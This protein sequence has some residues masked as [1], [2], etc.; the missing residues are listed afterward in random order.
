M[1]ET[2]KALLLTLSYPGVVSPHAS[3]LNAIGTYLLYDC[4]NFHADLSPPHDMTP[5]T[6]CLLLHI[7]PMPIIVCD[8]D[9]P[10]QRI[11]KPSVS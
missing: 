8:C 3:P 1:E 2:R 10:G 9:L 5:A 11:M 7:H 4:L 6:L